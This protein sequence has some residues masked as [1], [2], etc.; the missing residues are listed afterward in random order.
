[1][2]DHLYAAT[3]PSLR[4]ADAAFGSQPG[5][6]VGLPQRGLM[7]YL[8]IPEGFY[9]LVT[10]AGQEI[11]HDG[12]YVWPAGFHWAGLFTKVSHVVTKQHVVFDAPIKGCKTSDNVTVQI[13]TS[14][15]F[16]VMEDHVK[17]FVHEVSPSGLE[18]QLK[19]ALAEAI[20]TMAR[21]LKHTAVYACRTTI[22]RAVEA[23]PVSSKED[24]A[25]AEAKELDE[26]TGNAL[27]GGEVT[28]A[29]KQ[30]L[31]E[32]FQSQ[33]IQVVD[34]MIQDV[35]LPS[36][37]SKQMSN[38]TLVRSKQE[39]ER[40]TQK[41][42]MQDISL[43]NVQ[44][45]KR[46][47]YSEEQDRLRAE[48]EKQVHEA[49]NSLAE[50]KAVRGA[51]LN[52]YLQKTKGEIAKVHAEGKEVMQ[53]VTLEKE[54]MLQRLR[55]EGQAESNKLEADTKADIAKMDAET[56]MAVVNDQGDAQRALADAEK[57]ADA[58]LAPSRKFQLD[59]QRLATYKALASNPNLVLSDTRDKDTN[60][61]LLSDAIL[62][63]NDDASGSDDAKL[64]AHLNLLRLAGLAYG[65][66]A[67]P[68]VLS[69]ASSTQAT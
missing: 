21:S 27:L 56:K 58:F 51:E 18:Q 65:L 14:V 3:I 31:N 20:R 62:K 47:Q 54:A 30:R 15:V 8:M 10:R 1:M 59:D 38:K 5:L 25:T 68:A 50:R 48:G 29:M 12:S 7:P 43:K 49:R 34:V 36:E 57:R 19:D 6:M 4:G 60:L 33:G 42:D 32:Q 24:M 45:S 66:K 13:N 69:G 67:D 53:T 44:D 11:M 35:V 37:I 2:A 55:L 23:E 26:T 17:K 22:N 9:A 61:M 16:R 39:Y 64:L 52:A 63:Q 40:M 28:E 46:L 41:F